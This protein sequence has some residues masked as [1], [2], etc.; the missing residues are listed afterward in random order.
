V[1]CFIDTSFGSNC[2]LA[3]SD[4]IWPDRTKIEIVI[5]KQVVQLMVRLWTGMIYG[6][7]ELDVLSC[8]MCVRS[9]RSHSTPHNDS[10]I[11]TPIQY[12][13]PLLTV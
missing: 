3:L 2:I 4:L 11:S 7:M 12:F 5:F 9:D 1:N 8:S 13:E 10:R 6:D